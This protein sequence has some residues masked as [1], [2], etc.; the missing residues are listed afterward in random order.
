MYSLTDC[1]L[2]SENASSANLKQAIT[3]NITNDLESKQNG[4]R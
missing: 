2:L 3:K 4:T 1:T